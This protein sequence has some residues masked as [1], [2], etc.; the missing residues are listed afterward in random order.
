MQK[1]KLGDCIYKQNFK[2]EKFNIFVTIKFKAVR[3]QMN[4]ILKNIF[5]K[6]FNNMPN[7]V[8]KDFFSFEKE[9]Y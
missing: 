7:H 4:I 6:F 3:N 8:S 5:N 1:R 2:S 9:S